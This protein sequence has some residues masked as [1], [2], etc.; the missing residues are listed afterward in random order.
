MPWTMQR[1]RNQIEAA[2]TTPD[3]INKALAEL[4]EEIIIP[5]TIEP[6]R[7]PANNSARNSAPPPRTP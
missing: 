7:K 6:A 5:T 1:H 4:D 2:K 3:E